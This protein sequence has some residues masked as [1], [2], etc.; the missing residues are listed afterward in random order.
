MRY[1][2]A[3][4][5]F[6]ILWPGV[7]CDVSILLLVHFPF[8]NLFHMIILILRFDKFIYSFCLCIINGL[9]C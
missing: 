1:F 8:H 4:V 9:R 2:L 3:T 7:K 6:L 5:T